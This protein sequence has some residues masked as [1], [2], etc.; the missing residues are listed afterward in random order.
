M[1]MHSITLMTQDEKD[2]KYLPQNA[3]LN[4]RVG[5]VQQDILTIAEGMDPWQIEFSR[6][7]A[8]GEAKT[9]IAKDMKKADKTINKFLE[10]TKAQLLVQ[11]YK[12][13]VDVES[14]PSEAVR[15]N[16]LY[17]IAVDNQKLD[18]KEATK[19]IAELNKMDSNKNQG[20]GV[21]NITINIV[22]SLSKGALD[23]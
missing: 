22:D 7:Y 1:H 13:L 2:D 18:P 11:Y 23:A 20:S 19:A 9:K 17:E 10:T 12:L 15:K 5:R 6:R 16:M 3:S 8:N 14:G 21:G 4:K